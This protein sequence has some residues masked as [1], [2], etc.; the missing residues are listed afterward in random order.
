MTNKTINLTEPLY[1]YLL[2]VSFRDDDIARRLREE[3]AELENSGM[4]IAIKTSIAPARSLFRPRRR[5]FVIV[6]ALKSPRERR[7]Y[8]S[9]I[10][11][12]LPDSVRPLKKLAG[13]TVLGSD[14]ADT[15]TSMN[16]PGASV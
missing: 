1:D 9:F 4:Q 15:V 16:C 10:I 5:L 11:S 6:D 7:I 3:T 8:N 2:S 13:I 12:A 14:G